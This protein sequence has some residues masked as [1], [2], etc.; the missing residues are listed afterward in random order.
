MSR[1]TRDLVLQHA[2]GESTLAETIEQAWRAGYQA[3]EADR[4]DGV[5]RS[6]PTGLR[7]AAK[8]TV[9]QSTY[10]HLSALEWKWIDESAAWEP[11][12][13]DYLLRPS[14][15]G[16][17][18]ILMVAGGE[19]SGVVIVEGGRTFSFDEGTFS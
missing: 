6:E 17:A 8:T 2:C 12:G 19:Y 7:N 5:T 3:C 11:E 10:A 15:H 18:V 9:A 14:Q 13:S 4:V 16:T 1:T